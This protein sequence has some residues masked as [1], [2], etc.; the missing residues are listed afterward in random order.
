MAGDWIK[1]RGALLEHPKVVA[2]TRHLWI[3]PKFKSWILPGCL[4]PEGLVSD[5]ALRCVTCGALLRFWS[6]SREHG[7]WHGEDLV[8]KHSELVD[9]DQM[10]GVPGLGEAMLEVGWLRNSDG[11]ILPNFKEFNVP[12]TGAERQKVY[13]E[14]HHNESVTTPL[15]EPRHKTV[16]REEKRREEKK[17]D[18][19]PTPLGAARLVFVP[20]EWVPVEA[21][22]D[23]VEMRVRVRK[24]M[25]AR[26][27]ELAVIELGKLRDQGHEPKAVLE[28]SVARSWA[29]LFPIG[30]R[31]SR[32]AEA[33][34]AFVG[35]HHEGS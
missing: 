1:M 16:T 26:A 2:I 7:K 14:K 30:G 22:R 9:V 34:K 20:P 35:G 33:V 23:Y 12:M 32:S 27:K 3:N 25:T 8:L 17:E 18:N 15:R 13:R 21:W 6:A 29:G 11:L 31:T 10:S 19:P 5:A 4:A 24:P 28:Q